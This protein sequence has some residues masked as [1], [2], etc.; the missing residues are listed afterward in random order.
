MANFVFALRFAL[1]GC[2]GNDCALSAQKIL[3]LHYKGEPLS[4]IKIM[5]D[6]R[7]GNYIVLLKHGTKTSELCNDVKYMEAYGSPNNKS[8]K[9]FIDSREE[10]G[11]HFEVSQ[12]NNSTVHLTED[13]ESQKSLQTV[14]SPWAHE[15]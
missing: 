15:M 12:Y 9:L 3:S 6:E 7:D 2:E 14:Y 13:I 11:P 10:D 5:R 8:F 1:M 4:V